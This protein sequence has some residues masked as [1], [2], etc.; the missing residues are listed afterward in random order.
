M[1]KVQLTAEDRQDIEIYALVSKYRVLREVSAETLAQRLD[2]SPNTYY[3]KIKKPHTMT[4]RQLRTVKTCL[5][6]PT[7]EWAKVLEV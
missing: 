3:R 5:R 1:P 2:M 4:L 7:E 6:I